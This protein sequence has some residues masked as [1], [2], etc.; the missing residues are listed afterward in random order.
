MNGN[1]RGPTG[2]LRRLGVL[3]LPALAVALAALPASGQKIIDPDPNGY[4]QNETSLALIP[5]PPGLPAL[6][7]VAYNNDPTAATGLGVSMSVD[8]GLNWNALALPMPVDPGGSGANMTDA[9]D[10]AAAFDLLGNL[11]VEHISTLGGYPGASALFVTRYDSNTAMWYPPSTVA[12]S[13]AALG[14]PDPTYR[15]ND[16]CHLTTDRDPAGV[17]PYANNVYATWIRDGGYGVGPWSDIFFSTSA[18]QGATWTYP[19]GGPNPLPINDNPY[20]P[21]G[22][23]PFDMA[24]G[25]N[26]A[27]SPNGTVYVAWMDVDVTLPQ[28]TG[29]MMIDRSFNAGLTWGTDIVVQAAVPCSPTN[30][31]TVSR[32][33]ARARS[34]PCLAVAPNL[35]ANGQY[36]VYMVYSADPDGALPDEADVFFTSSANG[37]VTWSPPV[38]VNQDVSPFDQFEPWI[39]VKPNGWIDIAWYDRRLDPFDTAWD[40]AITRSIDG[41]MTFA[42]E[43]FLCGLGTAPTPH[44]PWGE[45][46]MGEYL[47]LGVDQTHAYVAFTSSLV[48]TLGDVYVVSVPNRAMTTAV[49]GTPEGEGTAGLR[50]DCPNPYRP[51]DAIRFA[52]PEAGDVRIAVYDAAG[53]LVRVLIAEPMGEGDHEVAWD[54]RDRDGASAARGVYFLRLER[55]ADRI[56]E[57]IVLVR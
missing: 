41:G 14:Y 33:D 30:L 35:N 38:R 56:A 57:K 40:V 34:Y 39:A 4:I 29:T 43:V 18:N 55:G 12:Y 52:L 49:P 3:S 51:G 48:D 20:A 27:V 13:P 44:M 23:P 31:S 16:K 50:L 47:G 5:G 9:F 2:A 11:F 54:G 22:T 26:V 15:F 28:T 45:Y 24:N 6:I 21:L 17:S 25:P 19:G 32:A 46:W 1:S 42:P 53:R 10:P 7:A 8:G 36:D 37:G